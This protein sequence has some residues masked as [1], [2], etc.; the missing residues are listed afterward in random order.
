[1]T[2]AL[3]IKYRAE[4]AAIDEAIAAF[5]SSGGVTEHWVGSRRVKREEMAMLYKRKRELE[6]ILAFEDKGTT[7]AYASWPKR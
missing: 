7:R 4:L 5:L 6:N 3:I 2:S 1:L